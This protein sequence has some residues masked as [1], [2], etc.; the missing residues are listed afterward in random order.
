[1]VRL[2][3]IT[4]TG[5]KSFA[6]KVTIPFP[7]GFNCIC[8]PNGSGKSNIVDAITFVLGTTSAKSIRAAKLQNLIFNG[9]KDRKPADYCEVILYIDNS[10]GKIP[11]CEKDVKITRRITR[12][13]ISVYK[14]DG[15]TETRNKVLDLLA[16]ANLSPEGYNIIMQGDITRI[17]EMNN[18]ER[19]GIID[20]VSGIAE[21]DEK[22]AKATS[23][24]EKVETRVRENMIVV[25]EKQRLVARLK[26]DKENAERY[27]VLNDKLRKSKASLLR[28]RIVEIETNLKKLDNDIQEGTTKL[29]SVD[30]NFID[31]ENRLDSTGKSILTKSDEIVKKARDY[32]LIKKIDGITTEILRKRDRIDMNEREIKRLEIRSPVVKAVLDQNL[33]DIYGTV[34]SLV[35]VPK[36]YTIAIE[37]AI[38]NHN[39]DIIV[40]NDSVAENCIKMLKEKKIGRARFL[41]LNKVKGEK[42]KG[43]ELYAIDVVEFDKKY[44]N[45]IEYILGSTAIADDI[46]KARKLSGRIVTLDGDLIEASG[47]MLGGFYERKFFGAE[48][49]IEEN[50]RLKK[51]I[52]GLEE[53]LNKLKEEEKTTMDEINKLEDEKT[54]ESKEVEELRMKRSQLYEEKILLQGNISKHKIE[55]ARIEASYES[56]KIEYGEYDDVKDFYELSLDK[57]QENVRTCITEIN[58]LGPINM[59]AIDEYHIISFEFDELKKK[60]DKLLEEKTSIMNVVHEVEKKRYE[61]FIETFNEIS[62]NFSR[63]YTDLMNGFGQLRLE[64]ENNIDSGLVIEASPAGKKVLN[65]DVMSGGEK[66]MTSLAFLF[67]ILEFYSAPFYILD[68]MDA[69]LDKA[70]VKKIVSLMKKYS[71]ER[72]FIVITHNDFTIQEADKVFGVSI[73]DGASKVFGIEMPKE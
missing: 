13:G 52:A 59:K 63:I 70:N 65:L 16:N 18:M 37:V 73:E 20:D 14:L 72:Q 4:M 31:I 49:F 64:I 17:I 34:S 1:M 12:S 58:Q 23:E 38:G 5:F 47:A 43:N 60:L 39:N 7:S 22:R 53:E 32:E 3:R 66:T 50:E 30:R 36:K 44:Q 42:K 67:S 19:R 11:G 27:K 6:G 51:E 15:K 55:S 61:K 24:L 28:K 68:E 40:S 9:G 48:R 29:E 71:K 45:A 35:K 21:F 8:G 54:K 41:P 57:L 69:A 25:A 46:G 33:P 2:D 26:E 56:I 62:K 10:D